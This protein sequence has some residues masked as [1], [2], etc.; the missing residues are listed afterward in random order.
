[1]VAILA[2]LIICGINA[3][4]RITQNIKNIM[5]IL[6]V[7]IAVL[8]LYIFAIPLNIFLLEPNM[9]LTKALKIQ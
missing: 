6:S 2:I 8:I 1:M 7:S 3:T 5:F 4:R 9:Y